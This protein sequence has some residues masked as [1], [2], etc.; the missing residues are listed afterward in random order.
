VRNATSDALSQWADTPAGRL[1]LDYEAAQIRK[2]LPESVPPE[3]L[4]WLSAFQC[5]AP[6]D[7][8][9][10]CSDLDK[11]SPGRNAIV[12]HEY[13]LPF[14]D[15]EFPRVI[16]AHVH[17]YTVE[18]H[19]Y[20]RELARVIEPEG[21]LIISGYNMFN[22]LGVG[23]RHRLYRRV[24]SP[25]YPAHYLGVGRLKDWLRLL[26]FELEGGGFFYYLPLT[27][28]LAILDRLR[29]MEAAGNRW[30]PRA[31][32]GFVLAA[33]KRLPGVT[34]LSSRE[35]LRLWAPAPQPALARVTQAGLMEK[36]EQG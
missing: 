3:Q 9:S 6:V 28:S 2:Q 11:L 16:S 15:N 29:W 30:W 10:V 35:K 7:A 17:E 33:R 13:E 24:G 4:L 14:F 8:L 21:Q 27:R 18:P 34:P 19:R 22:I 32:A 12:A 5:D 25:V 23:L 36:H 31:S 20:L 1:F 26:G